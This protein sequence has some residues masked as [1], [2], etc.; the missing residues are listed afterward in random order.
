MADV[1]IEGFDG[2]CI[3]FA[4]AREAEPFRRA[5][6]RTRR[7]ET[8]PF[9]S[10]RASIR[11]HQHLLILAPGV[12]R[13]RINPALDWLFARCQ[14]RLI[15][16]AGFAGGLHESLRIGD[17]IMPGTIADESGDEWATCWGDPRIRLLG[18]NRLLAEPIEKRGM[19]KLFG[20]VAVDM[21]SATIARRCQAAGIPVAALRSISDTVNMALSPRLLGLLAGGEVAPL[22]VAWNCVRSPRLIPECLRLAKH[23]HLAARNLARALVT[24][25]NAHELVGAAGS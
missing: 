17:V 15:I 13:D 8:A 25:L 22:K 12:G 2:V 5:W 11:K 16:S 20:A 19:S 18:T 4:L 21:E 10:W 3:C 9:P 7:I 23:T 1:V 24:Q 6:R 14:P